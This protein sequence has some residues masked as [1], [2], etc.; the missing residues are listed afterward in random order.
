MDEEWATIGHGS[1]RLMLAR[2]MIGV[3]DKLGSSERS[4]SVW[5]LRA[6][7]V[8]DGLVASTSFWLGPEGIEEGLDWFF[9]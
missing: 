3:S 8:A 9:G 7:L 4:S 2:D 1:D 6:R 5:S